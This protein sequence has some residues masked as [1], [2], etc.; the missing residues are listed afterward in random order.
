MA[1]FWKDFFVWVLS[2]FFISEF[3]DLVGKDLPSA[4][5]CLEFYKWIQVPLTDSRQIVDSFGLQSR[6]FNAIL[7]DV[8]GILDNAIGGRSVSIANQLIETLGSAYPPKV[9]RPSR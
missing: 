9:G 2:D 8:L 6:E 4:G 1:D 3:V 7:S 5:H